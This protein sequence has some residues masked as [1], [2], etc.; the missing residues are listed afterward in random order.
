MH[1]VAGR[2]TPTIRLRRLAGEL[3]RLRIAAA[4][5]VERVA[6]ETGLD[7]SSLYRVERALN[8]PQRRTVTTL[9]NLY[10]VPKDRQETLL[11]WLRDSGQQGWFRAYEPYLPEQYQTYISFE[12]DAERLRN[13]EN[14][15]VPGLLQTEDY[16]RAV[17][18]GVGLN[19]GDEDVQRRVEVRVQRQAVLHRPAPMQLHAVV[20]EAAIRCTVG[21]PAVMRAQLDRL[22]QAASQPNVRLQVIP[23]TAG[24]HPGLVGSFVVMDFAD[25]FDS[26][27]VYTD[28]PQ[29]DAFLE[30]QEE[31][32]RFAAMFDRT[33]GFALSPA[34]SKKLIQDAAKAV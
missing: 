26:P 10:D 7:Q 2:K 1:E 6:E 13:Y 29:G 17:V 22:A 25:P 18:E 15:F 3:K 4:L 11:G 21:G 28:G 31:V 12:Y 24:A 16:A 32:A 14:M 20:S 30:T 5:T 9:L 27:L 33:A 23:F 34:Q 19:L 8:K